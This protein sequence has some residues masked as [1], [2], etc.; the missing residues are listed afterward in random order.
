MRSHYLHI[1]IFQEH[2]LDISYLI[3]YTIIFLDT[4]IL[5]NFLTDLWAKRY[6]GSGLSKL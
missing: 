6:T 4:Y 5:V 1:R 2:V 3:I